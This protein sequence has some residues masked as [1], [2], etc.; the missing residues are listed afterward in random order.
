MWPSYT[1]IPSVRLVI[2]LQIYD[3]SFFSLLYNHLSRLPHHHRTPVSISL[4]T[5]YVAQYKLLVPFW[6]FCSLSRGS[7][8]SLTNGQPQHQLIPCSEAV[9]CILLGLG[10]IYNEGLVTLAT[11]I[12][13]VMHNAKKNQLSQLVFFNLLVRARCMCLYRTNASANFV[14]RPFILLTT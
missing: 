11:D 13:H 2:C 8:C 12:G 7:V 10:F 3:F 1:S 14:I 9:V 5:R 4:R 6:G